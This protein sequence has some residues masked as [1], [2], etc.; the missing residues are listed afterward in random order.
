MRDLS[1][2]LSGII[3]NIAGRARVNDARIMIP[4]RITPFNSRRS[5]MQN[6]NSTAEH[7]STFTLPRATNGDLA[8]RRYAR[9]RQF[10]LRLAT[11]QLN[12]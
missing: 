2:R 9:S 10:E 7:D 11:N 1:K 6:V 4:S 8:G 3:Q 12:L 5:N